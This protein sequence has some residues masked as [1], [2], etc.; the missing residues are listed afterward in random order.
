MD[1]GGGKRSRKNKISVGKRK[2]GVGNIFR[3][4]REK[5]GGEIKS[6]EERR[7]RKSDT[8]K[9]LTCIFLQISLILLTKPD[10][11]DSI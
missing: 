8:I 7:E 2:G 11:S 10:F 6:K 5:D 1:K 4:S 3:I 9:M